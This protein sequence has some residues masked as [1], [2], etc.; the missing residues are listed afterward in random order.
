VDPA[1]LSRPQQQQLGYTVISKHDTGEIVELGR[2]HKPRWSFGGT[3]NP[4]DAWVLPNNRVVVA[5]YTSNKVSMRDLK[6]KVLW[7]KQLNGNPHNVQPLPNGN[8]FIASNVQIAE[9]DR[10]GKDVPIRELGQLINNL[11][12]I[13]GA[14]KARN[15][16]IV[17][18]GQNGQCV[19]L[20]ANGKQ[21]KS[22]N[23]NRGNAW[24]DVLP[25]GRI[26]VAQNGG[27]KV[28]EYDPDGKL[29]LELDVQQVSM[30]TGLPNGNILVACHSM[31]RMMEMDRKG[32]VIWEYKTQGPFRARGR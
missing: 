17:V 1:K 18:M 2:D 6:G 19:R 28:A 23:T 10:N 24:L 9:V 4:V 13:T 22:F 11:G 26:L 14:Y 3:Q 30:A 20:D 32:K 15:G 7:Q 8:I 21:L 31:G 25:N 5:E 29:L 16:H 27:N 12:Q